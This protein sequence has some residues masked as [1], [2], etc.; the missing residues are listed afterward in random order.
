M[1]QF[2]FLIVLVSWPLLALPV[3][4]QNQ[5]DR[6]SAY[7]IRDAQVVIEPGTVLPKATVVIRD[8]LI[9]AVGEDVPI[10]P[11]AVVTEGK[12]M[13]LYPGFIDGGTSRGFDATLRRSQTGA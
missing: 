1:K 11:D 13:T 9:V 5:A 2:R 10:P 6:P 3:S 7:A 8:G 12:G 4:A